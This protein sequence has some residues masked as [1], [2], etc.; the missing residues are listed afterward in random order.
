M[1]DLDVV[2][3]PECLLQLACDFLEEADLLLQVELHLGLEVAHADLVKMLD[4]GQR[5]EGDDVAALGDAFGLLPLHLALL[6]VFL[7]LLHLGQS[8]CGNTAGLD[9]RIILYV[10]VL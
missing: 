4:L 9:V 5:G 3:L 2:V 8:S 1:V 10:S 6:H 7:A